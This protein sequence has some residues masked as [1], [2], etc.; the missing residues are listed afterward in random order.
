MKNSKN[1]KAAR[2]TSIGL[3][4]KLA[5]E[6]AQQLDDLLTTYHVYY[7]NVRGYHWNLK[8]DNFFV[9]HVKFEELY[10]DLQVKIDE[11]AERIRTLS[12]IPTHAFSEYL[13]RSEIKES[14]NVT[15]GKTAVGLILDGLRIILEKERLILDL[16]DEDEGTHALM[17]DYIRQ[18][19]KLVWMY[20]AY[21]NQP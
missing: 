15:D 13:K 6:L 21:L 5:N 10:N 2:T 7:I 16:S 14:T 19:E 9:L 17:S 4:P 12:K 20:S 1:K 8:G 3:E 18:Q 11:I